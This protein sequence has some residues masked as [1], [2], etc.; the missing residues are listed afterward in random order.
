[1]VK[2]AFVAPPRPHRK[3]APRN[4]LERFKFW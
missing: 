1:V 2:H 3:P 4:L